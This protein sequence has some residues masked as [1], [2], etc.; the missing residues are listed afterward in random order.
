MNTEDVEP[1]SH[2]MDLVNVTRDDVEKPSLPQKEA[3]ANAPLKNDK[4]FR[5]PKV[6]SK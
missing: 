6:V 3:L 1:L 5:V 2:S 4:F